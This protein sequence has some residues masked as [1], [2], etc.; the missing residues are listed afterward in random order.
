MLRKSRLQQKNGFLIKK[1]VHGLRKTP[2]SFNILVMFLDFTFFSCTLFEEMLQCPLISVTH[3]T[4][5]VV[6]M[7]KFSCMKKRQKERF[8][9][10]KTPL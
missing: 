10:S 5:K 9:H 4:L 1:R 7:K 3:F 6:K 8:C 2:N